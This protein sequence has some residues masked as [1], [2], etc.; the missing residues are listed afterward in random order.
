MSGCRLCLASSCP[1]SRSKRLRLCID[2]PLSAFDRLWSSGLGSPAA[3]LYS[4]AVPNPTYLSSQLLLA[5]PGIDDPRF[6]RA[7]IAMCVHDE[8]GAMGIGDRKSV[9]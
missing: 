9:V 8:G 1:P 5:M 2:E 6:E 3:R 4:R 7:V